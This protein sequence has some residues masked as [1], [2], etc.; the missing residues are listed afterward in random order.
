MDNYRL[1]SEDEI[2]ALESRGCRA[3]DWTRV[4]VKDAFD[5][6]RLEQVRFYGDVRLGVYVCELEVEPGIMRPT[7]IYRAEL[8]DVTIGNEALIENI[9]S[10]IARYDIGDGAYVSNVGRITSSGQSLFGIGTP[11]QVLTE[12]SKRFVVYLHEK[13]TAQ[14]FYLRKQAADAEAWQ[15]GAGACE[16]L[17][18][19][20]GKEVAS[21]RG[22]RAVI[23]ERAT[24]RNVKEI[25]NTCIGAY[26]CVT[27]ADS[28]VECSL[29]ST[30]HDPTYVTDGG[31]CKHS[32]LA[33]GSE[34]T[35]GA[36]VYSCFVGQHAHLGKG[37]SAEQ[38]LFF[39]DSYMDNGEACAVCAGPFTVSH[40]KSTLLIGGMLSFMNAG[41]GTN[42]SNHM[43]KTGP[44]HYGVLGRGCKTASGTHLV[45]PGHI[46]D[47]SMVMGK[48][49]SHP[50]L[51][52]FPFSYVFNEKDGAHVVPGI[53]FLT[54]GTYRDIRKWPVR[55]TRSAARYQSDYLSAF[56]ALNPHSVGRSIAGRRRLEQIVS[57]GTFIDGVYR[58]DGVVMTRKDVERGITLYRLIE[59]LYIAGHVEVLPANRQEPAQACHEW[60]DM[61][62][63][64]LPENRVKE[65]A[66]KLADGEYDSMDR[67]LDAFDEGAKAYASMVSEDI[68]RC[69]ARDEIVEALHRYESNLNRYY[70]ALEA[71]LEK[72]CRLRENLPADELD[73]LRLNLHK[74]RTEALNK[75]KERT[76]FLLEGNEV[77][78]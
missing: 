73:A 7:G 18:R 12:A 45:W 14:E 43:Y 8:H 65:I 24:V 62:G 49:D 46:G 26:A 51:Q 3:E 50:A 68:C 20:V 75:A 37:F 9:G 29:F 35:D 58:K 56:E 76:S 16:G 52:D 17:N 60:H 61:L 1:L 69:Y 22:R 5:P 77:S 64:L 11:V 54:F 78:R 32:V 28:L 41:S 74:D 27:G 63:L 23:R 47:F 71:D 48:C 66:G 39:A 13:L 53:N 34:V 31:L 30:Q 36:K 70:D 33:V 15:D 42:M 19:L 21:H 57:S 4:L 72:D 67:L 55:Y 2:R 38:S 44:V 10:Y 6:T 25:V 59:E 40:H